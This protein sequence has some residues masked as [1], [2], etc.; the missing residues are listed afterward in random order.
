MASYKITPVDLEG[1]KNFCEDRNFT[2]EQD[3]E[4]PTKFVV[5]G[6]FMIDGYA[7]NMYAMGYIA[8]DWEIVQKIG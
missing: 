5:S 4:D 2:L 3:S 1:L 6:M 8:N 7:R